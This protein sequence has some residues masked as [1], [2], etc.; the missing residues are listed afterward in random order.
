M[1]ARALVLQRAADA[2]RPDLADDAVIVANELVTNAMLH[3]GGC[4]GVEVRVTGGGLRLEVYD[5]SRVPPVMGLESDGSLTGRGL[6]IVASIAG[7]WG[8]DTQDRGKVVWAEIT[9]E[10]R[11]DLDDLHDEDLLA[12]WGDDWD[13]GDGQ[14]WT[15]EIGDVPT[16]LLLAAKSH[17]DNVAR[18]FAL[19]SAGAAS[20]LTPEVPARLATLLRTVVEHFAEARLAIKHQAIQAARRGAATTHLTLSLPASAAQAAEEYLNALDEVDSY[21][22]AARLLT[23]ETPPQH[24]AFRQWYVSEVVSQLRAASMG[25]PRPPP[26]SFEH[27]LLAELDR[28][29][30]MQHVAARA[31]RLYSV[32]SALATAATPE[33]VAEVVLADGVAALGAAGGGLLL[34]TDHEQLALPGSVGYAEQVVA[35]L[36]TESRH[37]EL[38]AAAALRTGEAVWLESRTE[39]DARFPELVGLEAGTVSLCA[40]PLVIGDRRLGALRFSFSEARL[41][42]EDERRFVGALAALTT[43]A[44]DRA[45]LQRA[46]LDA[47][48]RLQRSLLPPTLPAIPGLELAALYHPFGDGM[49]VG[50]DFY[51]VWPVGD[52]RWALAIGDAA[53]TGPEA[54]SLTGVARH[55]A[56]ALTMA[57]AGPEEVI[58]KL[59]TALLRATAD[60]ERFC[61]V[62]FGVVEGANPLRVRLAGGGHPPVLVRRADGEI[63]SHVVGGTVLGLFEDTD[64]GVLTLE[65]TAGDTLLLL[66]DG[67]LEARRAGAQF[68]VDGVRAVLSE[69]DATAQEVVTA[70]E[71]A[72]LA[73]SGGSLND[74]MAALVLR[75]PAT[76]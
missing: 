15:V 27:W 21:S 39:R 33:A 58:A 44:L 69:T 11:D 29:V 24:R 50:G 65:L 38:P 57:S 74:D 17:V 31:A 5:D 22:R 66:T 72:V 56:R 60:S 35:R 3:G 8:A 14:R 75:V 63:S 1:R 23:L 2:G 36:R 45:Q 6:R 37:A 4:T 46:R 10:G 47:S 52:R 64:I 73:H 42:D 59:N 20:G 70:L 34:A 16:D 62:L 19:A 26:V 32:A 71:A 13:W 55:T 28:V 53:G 67:V 40:V 76:E 30:E 48:R 68:G 7:A 43:Q 12:M 51:D 41:F 25:T 61:T 54:A 9:G 18:E 49:D